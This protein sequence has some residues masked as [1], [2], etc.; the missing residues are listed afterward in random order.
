MVADDQ[1]EILAGVD[2]I[3]TFPGGIAGGSRLELVQHQIAV[4][5]Q[6]GIG[7]QNF[8]R[9]D[10]FVFEFFLNRADEDAIPTHARPPIN[11]DSRS[12]FRNESLEA[13]ASSAFSSPSLSS[14]RICAM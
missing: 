7:P 8:L 12:S 3:E 10:P 14:F 5:F 9:T 11:I 13:K 2:F 1:G 6:E 4:I